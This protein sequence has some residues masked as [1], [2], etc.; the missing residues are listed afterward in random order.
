MAHDDRRKTEAV[1]IVINVHVA[2][3]NSG[4]F[5]L[6]QDFSFCEFRNRNIT[7][8]QF[9]RFCHPNA[10]H[11]KYLL[12]SDRV[13]FSEKFSGFPAP[14]PAWRF[15]RRSGESGTQPILL[16]LHWFWQFFLRPDQHSP[17][18]QRVRIERPSQHWPS[19]DSCLLRSNQS[20]HIRRPQGAG[21]CHP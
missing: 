17:Q 20:H 13:V 21:R 18:S 4:I 9:G 3:A 8:F 14:L 12:F 15:R 6:E 11:N 10:P 5:H 16:T 1:R 2:A 7:N 19:I